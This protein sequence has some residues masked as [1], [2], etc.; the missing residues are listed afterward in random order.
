MATLCLVP[1]QQLARKWRQAAAQADSDLR[2]FSIK[3][4]V[5]H[6][7]KEQGCPYRDSLFLEQI[8]VWEAVWEAAPQLEYFAGMVNFPGFAADLHNLFYRYGAEQVRFD[9]LSHQEQRE[10]TLLYSLYQERLAE[11]GVLD[12]AQQIREA[13]QYWPQSQLSRVVERIELYYL[14]ELTTLEQRLIETICRGKQ[15]KRCQ[16]SDRDAVVTAAAAKRPTEEIE[17]VARNIVELLNQGVE[18]EK[19]AVV[20]PDLD[21]YL[22]VIMPIFSRYQLPWQPPAVKLADTPM[23]KAVAAVIRVMQPKWSKAD[24]EQ[25]TAP[26]WGLPFALDQQEHKALKLA[27]PNLRSKEQWQALLGEYPGWQRVFQVLEQLEIGPGSYPISSFLERLQ[28]LFTHLPLA[29]WPALDHQQWAVLQQSYHGLLQISADLMGVKQRISFDQFEQIW[30]SAAAAY[31]LP[32]PRSFLQ[33]IMVGSLPQAVGM[34]YHT[35]FMV[36]ITETSFPKPAKRDWLSRQF[37]PSQ[38]LALYRQLLRS[39]ENVQLSFAEEDQ[40]DRM[41][42]ASQ[43]F[44]GEFTRIN[45]AAAAPP[46]EELTIGSGVLTDPAVLA[47][48]SGK[49]REQPLSVSRLNLYASCPFRFLC[50]E[51]YQLEAEEML[52][53]E[54]TPQEEGSLIHDTLRLYWEHQGRVPINEILVERYSAAGERLTQRVI[55]LVTAFNRKDVELVEKS[56]YY[57]KYLEQ[58]FQDLVIETS[59]GKIKLNGIIDR[60]DL[61]PD[62]G[63]VIYD[64]KTGTSPSVREILQGENLQL[65]VYLL[66]A[67]SLLPGKV[68][69]MAFYNIGTLARTGLWLESTHRSLGLTKRSSGIIPDQEWEQLT[70]DFYR[71]LQTYLERILSGY[72][73]IAP[74]NDR[75]CSFCP[76]RAICRKE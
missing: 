2:P 65:Q 69:G 71:T 5:A 61:S 32:Q 59:G 17:Q 53:D 26:G 43:I 9:Q 31:N 60:I 49:Y 18:P 62:G 3:E 13:V 1:H 51:L 14:G 19:I 4:L 67:G 16:F 52:S 50:S 42:I 11:L 40:A 30:H 27:P 68:H 23:G 38:D 70:A 10:L 45:A 76:Y 39:A 36:G 20:S 55:D 74:V 54:I 75:V 21:S 64:Y 29:K 34:G 28:R 46:M 47:D 73:P 7:L 12:Q 24:L 37:V 15:V 57:P 22:P 25:L 6:L 58:R 63:Y 8:A 33:K 72:F 48:I 35:L 56:G 66:A 44:P 41:N